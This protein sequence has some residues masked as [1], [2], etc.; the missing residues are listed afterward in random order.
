MNLAETHAL[1]TL[2]SGAFDNRRFDDATVLAWQPI[3]A[4]FT[5]DDCR[6]AVTRHF[7]ESSEYLMPAHVKA[8]ARE[9]VRERR[10]A[11]REANEAEELRAL[12]ADPTRRDRSDAVRGLIAELRDRLPDGDPDKL[13][14]SEWIEIDRRRQRELEPNPYYVGPP[15]PDGHPLPESP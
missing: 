13:L 6:T 3:F 12:E 10:R 1:L 7:A 14:R 15:P 9:V 4:E 11:K 5:F 2:I 8:G